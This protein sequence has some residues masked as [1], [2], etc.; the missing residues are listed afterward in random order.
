[1]AL[2]VHIVPTRLACFRLNSNC[3]IEGEAIVFPVT[4]VCDDEVSDLKKSIRSERA[5]DDVGPHTLKLW[6]VSAIDES[7]SEVTLAYFRTLTGSHSR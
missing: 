1:V 3:L 5:L 2:A 6:K 7:L 4:A